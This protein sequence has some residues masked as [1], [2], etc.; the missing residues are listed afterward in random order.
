MPAPL[1]DLLVGGGEAA[2]LIRE[3][4]WSRTPVGAVETWSPAMRAMVGLVLRNRFPL[5]LWWGPSF[6]QF[7][8]DAYAPIPGHK[9]PRAMGQ[10]AAEC[11]PGIW[12]VIGP[13]IEAPFA[14][15]PAT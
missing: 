4:D 5:L 12:S 11:W 15:E 8:N 7:Y 9:H 14:G 6:V 3:V 2:A 10:P 13:M 1:D